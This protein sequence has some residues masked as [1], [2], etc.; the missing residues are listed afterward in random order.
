M[1]WKKLKKAKGCGWRE[2]RKQ[3]YLSVC[4]WYSGLFMD[5]PYNAQTAQDQVAALEIQG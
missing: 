4:A 3:R 5:M 2:G 1:K